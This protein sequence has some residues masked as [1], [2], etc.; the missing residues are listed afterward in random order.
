MTLMTPGAATGTDPDNLDD[1][2]AAVRFAVPDPPKHVVDRPRLV[3]LLDRTTEVP[4]TL[5]SAPAG[6]GKTALVASWVAGRTSEDI[7]WITFEDRDGVP[8]RQF[9]SDLLACVHEHLVGPQP[10]ADQGAGE[11]VDLVTALAGTVTRLERRLT[12]VLD[13]CELLSSDLAAD[14][15]YVLRH[16]NRL[17]HVVLL[18]RVDPVLPLHRYRLEETVL[19]VRLSHLAFT[20]DETRELTE[21]GGVDLTRESLAALTTRTRGWVAGLRFATML[22][23]QCDDPDVAVRRLAG[24]RGNIAEYLMAE[25]LETQSEDVRALLMHT[26]VVDVLQPGLIEELGGTGA[27]RMLDALARANVLVESLPDRPG[28]YRYHPFLRDLLRA[29][30]AYHAPTQRVRLHLRAARWFAQQGALAA[31]VDV[32]VEVGAWSKAARLVVEDLAIGTLLVGDDADELTRLFRKLPADVSDP[33]CA[34]LRAALAAADG[35]VEGC[36][37]E[38]TK[39]RAVAMSR[40][41]AYGR[42]V[43]LA[44]D[45]IDAVRAGLVDDPEALELTDGVEHDLRDHGA[46]GRTAHCEL[47]ALLEIGKGEWLLRR[48][49][50]GEARSALTSGSLAARTAGVESLMARGQAALA[51]VAALG[52]ELQR[53]GE[54]ATDAVARSALVTGSVQGR[55]P[56][57]EAHLALAWVGVEQYELTAAEEHLRAAERS[58]PRRYDPLRGALAAMVKGRLLRART[59]TGS[60]IE[61]IDRSRADVTAGWLRHRLEVEGAAIR[62][63]HGEAQEAVGIIDGLDDPG[64]AESMLVIGAAQLALGD[65][66]GLRECV[67]DLV[68]RRDDMS[69]SAQVRGGVLEASYELG[70]REPQRAKVAL[71]RSLRAAAPERLRR[72]FL[73]APT[74][75]RELLGAD[76]DL[77]QHASWLRPSAGSRTPVVPLQRKVGAVARPSD[78]P[79]PDQVIEPL[80]AKELEVL[81]HLSELLSTEEIAAAMFVSVNT[82]RTHVRSILRKLAVSRRNEAV[83]RGRALGLVAS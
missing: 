59:H 75:V 49:R 46:G 61:L 77:T 41:S 70:R 39:A 66:P 60:A 51:V 43:E 19:E 32:A 15:D 50:L 5:V 29:E 6:S 56:L 71:L 23:A 53:A 64:T 18:T 10:S 25:I 73:E 40:H 27:P 44:A 74:P 24:D 34:L 21:L 33:D 42:S 83:R 55:A 22:L 62:V 31:A 72:P 30:L 63:A 4:L 12:V 2:L 3:E 69:L 65:K 67:T 8:A 52:G 38:L 82:I 54:L 68:N 13:G 45:L 48:G 36:V 58:T 7:A 47:V 20:E 81:G 76:A 80:T 9:W 17:L 35:D 1:S 14:L 79:P 11:A 57:G 37:E 26:S 28:W 78:A 16:S